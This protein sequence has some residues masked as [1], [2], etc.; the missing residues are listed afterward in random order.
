MCQF[1]FFF[2]P[3]SRRSECEVITDISTETQNQIKRTV[4]YGNAVFFVLFLG[5]KGSIQ[6]GLK[7]L[8]FTAA[9]ITLK[10]QVF[11]YLVFCFAC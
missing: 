10:G 11:R 3:S 5:K 4:R 2:L 1:M 8:H 9:T 6:P 7:A